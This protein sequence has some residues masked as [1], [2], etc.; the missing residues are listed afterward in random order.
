MAT[1]STSAGR[2]AFRKEM[3][4]PS[5]G[6]RDELG[7]ISLCGGIGAA[8]RAMDLLG[9]ELGTFV[10]AECDPI[11][12]RVVK[13]HWPEVVVWDDV[14]A[15]TDEQIRRVG[16]EAPHLTTLI[17][18]AGTPCQ[19]L[20]GAN[21]T[22][23]GL[24]GSKSSLLFDVWALRCRI[25]Q[26]LPWLRVLTLIENVQSMDS[27]GSGGREQISQL[28]TVKPI[29]ACASGLSGVRRPRYWWVDWCI[30]EG[31]GV[32]IKDK[33]HKLE[34]RFDTSLPD[35]S[36]GLD[37]GWKRCDATQPKHATFM[38]A[39]RRSKPPFMPC[40]IDSCDPATLQRW[41]T[42]EYRYPPYQYRESNLVCRGAE[43]R[44]LNSKER[45]VQMG[46]A[47]D[48]LDAAVSKRDTSMTAQDKEDV[49]C[50][51]VGNSYHCVVVGWLIGQALCA[52][53][54]RN[55]APSPEECWGA[56]AEQSS[57]N[58]ECTA[59][60]FREYLDKLNDQEFNKEATLHLHRGAMY[61]GSDIRMS[62][63][64][65]MHPGRWPRQAMPFKRWKWKIVLSFHQQGSHINVLELK[66]IAAALRWR[67]RGPDSV[68]TRF[69]HIT[70]SQ[71]CQSVLV[72]GRSSSRQLRQV[73]Q[74]INS[75]V[76]VSGLVP[77]YGYVRSCENPADYPSR[78]VRR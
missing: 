29:A 38:R 40:G 6:G 27:H 60:K 24:S 74:R 23:K 73:L 46:F 8:R 41:E 4:R 51:L 58:E 70:D 3:S 20:S 21:A 16:R 42:D 17:V 34:V 62:T 25:V 47:A 57:G 7:L 55:R 49:R 32:T 19:D 30:K 22:G 9:H 15:V 48:H 50:S 12:V 71:V 78:W 37:R 18:E 52:E 59:I 33:G 2:S 54:L 76:L 75:L 35:W 28:T 36:F 39:I 64:T 26:L 65:V 43:M 72:K 68:R 77:A 13:H 31:P 11:A 69:V 45:C 1:R 10:L 44:P 61:K 14:R 53:G 67:M 56:I 63:G 66:A 5:Q